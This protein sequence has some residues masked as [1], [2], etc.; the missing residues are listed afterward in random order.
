MPVMNLEE[1]YRKEVMPALRNEF[2]LKNVMAIPRLEKAIVHTGVGKIREDKDQQEIRKFLTLITGQKP[3]ARVAKKAIAAF[4]TRRGLVIGYQVTLRGKRMY[5]FLSR[6]VTVALPRTR[7]FRGIPESACDGRGNLTIGVREHIVFPEM[8]NEDYRLL[9]GM[10]VT[11]VT[12][13]KRREHGIAL[14]KMMGFPL[15]T[16]K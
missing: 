8:I 9:F 4:K 16:Q 12:T 15:E 2:A 10:E 7:D 3:A 13:A 6:L 14:L 11:V 5:D 1:K